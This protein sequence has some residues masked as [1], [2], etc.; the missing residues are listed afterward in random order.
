[1][2]DQ[3][4]FNASLEGNTCDGAG[5]AWNPTS[6]IYKVKSGA[7]NST[8]LGETFTA[9]NCHVVTSHTKMKCDF[10]AGAGKFHEWVVTVGKQESLTP[11]S[12]Y[13]SPRIN[14]ITGAGA[15]NGD[16]NGN[17]IVELNGL[18]F[19]PYADGAVVTYGVSGVEYSPTDC[20]VVSH[21]KITCK[22]V[23]GIGQGLFWRVTVREQSN[24]LTAT[25]SYAA[26]IINSIS[27]GVFSADGSDIRDVLVFLNVSDSGLADPLSNI[28][29]QLDPACKT[30]VEA[31]G[32]YEIPVEPVS[33]TAT[34]F[35]GE[36]DILAFR[37]P[38]LLNQKNAKE[39]SVSMVVF[40]SDR[41]TGDVVRSAAVKSQNS[42]LFSYSQPVIDQIVV[43][44]HPW[45]S[46]MR[47]LTV[48]GRNFGSIS[49]GEYPK[50]TFAMRV[51]NI[52]LRGG[53]SDA[54]PMQLDVDIRDPSRTT[55][56]VQKWERGAQN[57]R[58]DEITVI[59]AGT[60]KGKVS[61]SR[62]GETSNEVEFEDLTPSIIGNPKWERIVPNQNPVLLNAV[63]TLGSKVVNT[64]Q[65]NEEIRMEINCKDCGTSRQMCCTDST[66]SVCETECHPANQGIPKLV[67][68]WL[69][70]SQLPDAE[71]KLC[72][73]VEGSSR[74]DTDSKMW[75]YHCQVPPYQ[76]STV[77]TRINFD[78]RWSN[79]TSTR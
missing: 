57:E 2:M 37:V 74:Y 18:N 66:K 44:E 69:G 21:Q 15:V 77:D 48:I 26:P 32:T 30:N 13:N 73:I 41:T 72:P 52:P 68:I 24:E 31:C 28:V 19:G 49:I 61:I 71:L 51:N 22:T 27:P 29:V 58:H 47:K 14:S 33:K 12:S 11:T 65:G 54:I 50:P 9:L 64:L 39:I 78:G 38:M 53:V 43:T 35:D 45:I 36:F 75:K 16:T 70:S 67:E 56:Y 6:A 8:D 46:G 7:A 20:L 10:V 59:W 63:P 34:R 55:S 4:C 76:G 60:S 79:A 23:P 17:Q 3:H 40:P 42:V 5:V 62:G 1:M 25:S